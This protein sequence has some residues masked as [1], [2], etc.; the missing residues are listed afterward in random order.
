[1]TDAEKKELE[2]LKVKAD[3][4]DEENKPLEALEA[5]DKSDDDGAK[6][7]TYSESYVKSLRTENAKYRTRAKEADAE[8]ERLKATKPGNLDA[9]DQGA[10]QGATQSGVG[11]IR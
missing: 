10:L 3:K 2:A 8:V 4:S 6:E 7:K 5:K 11:A 9:E 1:M